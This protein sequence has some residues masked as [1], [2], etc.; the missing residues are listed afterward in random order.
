[1]LHP[2]RDMR[3]FAAAALAGVIVLAGSALAQN[4]V[5]A[6]P[7]VEIAFNRYYDY[8]EMTAL[9]RRLAEAHPNLV[10]IESIGKSFE[11]RDL[12]LATVA[13]RGGAPL[14]S[15]PA[16]WID[17]NVH[18]NEVQGSEACLY[19]LWYLTEQYPANEKVRELLDSCVFYILPSQNPDGRE[20]WFHG[21]NTAHSSRSGKKPLDDDRDGAADEDPPNDL[22]GDGSITQ[23]RKKVDKGGTHLVDPDDPRIMKSAQPDQAGT[24]VM[25][26]SEGID[27]DGDGEINEDG[28]G[29]YDM[30]RNWPSDWQPNSV[31][32]GAGDYPLSYPECRAVAD[33]IFAR[34]N[35]AALQSYHNA[36]G[37]ILRGPG[38]QSYGEYPGED[39]EVYDRL[40]R[41]GEEM[42][43]FYRYLVI[44]KDLYSVRGGFVTWAY[45]G[46]G[47]F[48]LTTELWT[49]P[50]Y[51]GKPDGGEG[52]PLS[53]LRWDDRVELGARFASWK[54]FKHPLYGDV[55][56]G[57]WRKDTGRVPPTFM[58]EEMCHRNMAFTL[59]HASEMPRLEWDPPAVSEVSPGLWR[60][61]VE[62]R[63]TRAIPTRAA[64][65]RQKRIGTP[66]RL[67]ITPKNAVVL[68][69]GR[70]VGPFQREHAELVEHRPDRLL[71]DGGVRG[72]GR[73]RAEWLLSSPSG[74]PQFSL[75]F[76]AEK[77]GVLE[78]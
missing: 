53:R 58:L 74:P 57:G 61:R 2:S 59:Y 50:Q 45:E 37:M 51:A 47:I 22:D 21:P 10:T 4:P 52:Q 62:I 14:D 71:L 76:E 23:M 31:Q 46:L 6:K 3:G 42:L 54:P 67:V 70:L 32:S 39:V 28:P 1:M 27:D 38:A 63:N 30:N 13:A 66:D 33:A 9:L 75:R 19:T 48:A 40:G 26:G 55:E 78:R 17:A 65:A 35:I 69:G 20:W 68:A 77:G 16:M 34:K 73:V 43:P 12:W 41:T 7:K 60:V 15:R 56:V 25:L 8:G 29:G 44:W 64:V 5:S 36:G 11:G 72:F 49:T 24:H 18:G